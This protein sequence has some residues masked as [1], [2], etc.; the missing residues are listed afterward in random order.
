[1]LE[2]SLLVPLLAIALELTYPTPIAAREQTL[3]RPNVLII[4]THVLRSRTHPLIS[5]IAI[6][7]AGR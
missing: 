6:L 5:V 3:L 7:R 4:S 2:K 1:M